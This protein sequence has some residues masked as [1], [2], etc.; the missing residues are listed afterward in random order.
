MATIEQFNHR[1]REL[2]GLGDW[3][4]GFR[5]AEERGAI[6]AED[7]AGRP[8]LVRIYD[9]REYEDVDRQWLADFLFGLDC[10]RDE[11]YGAIWDGAARHRDGLDLD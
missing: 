3:A 6:E 10:P 2:Q 9:A 7:V 1:L 4:P 8:D 5:W 11:A